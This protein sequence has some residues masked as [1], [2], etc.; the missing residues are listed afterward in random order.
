VKS[1]IENHFSRGGSVKA[2][3]ANGLSSAGR[4]KSVERNRAARDGFVNSAD[5]HTQ[6]NETVL[7]KKMYF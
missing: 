7:K 2:G 4:L 1:T 3:G 5:N 6:P